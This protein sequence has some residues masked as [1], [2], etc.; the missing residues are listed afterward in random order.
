MKNTLWIP[1]ALSAV[2]LGACGGGGEGSTASN[3]SAVSAGT[4]GESGGTQQP[5]PSITDSSN[6]S[7]YSPETRYSNSYCADGVYPTQWEWRS[8]R[9]RASPQPATSG[10]P[11][12]K[13]I[14]NGV[15]IA[16]YSKLAGYRS[17]ADNIDAHDT[18]VGP[19]RRMPYTQMADGD[20]FEIYPAVYEGEDQQIF[21]GPN[22]KND[23]EYSAGKTY[24]PKNITIRGITVNGYRPVIKNPSS[25]ASGNTLNQAL[26]YVGASE[27]VTIENIDVMDSDTGG[28]IGKAGIY[29]SGARDLTLKNVRVSGFKRHQQNGIF[30]TGQN[31]GTLLLQGVE[32]ENNGGAGGP[33]HNAYLNGSATDNNFTVKLQGSWSH[34]TYYGHLFKSRAQVTIL[35][36]NYFQGGSANGTVQA[37]TYLVDIPEGGTLVARNNVFVKNFSGDNS[38]GAAIT[39]AVEAGSATKPF[40]AARPWG[41]TVEHNTFVAFSRYYDTQSH[42]LYPFFFKSTAPVPAA[43]KAVRNNFFVGYCPTASQITSG[44]YGDSH[45]EGNFNDIDAAF[46][47]RKPTLMSGSTI[48]G[49]L[50][51]AHRNGTAARTTTAA[52]ARD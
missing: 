21:V 9:V 42:R 16:T 8:D 49:T 50:T 11:L 27:N 32:L 35:E 12:I 47:P 5:L 46:R 19:F 44:Y 25:G 30:G 4:T 20:V 38:N 37:E 31:S 45:A 41:L 15:V 26:V 13:H 1:A 48:V 23:A 22:V 34:N 2:L 24:T 3:N 43:A 10:T 40:D 52:G 33:E 6:A 28:S 14:R 7:D 18:S 39:F 36:G 51:Y 29:V 17:T